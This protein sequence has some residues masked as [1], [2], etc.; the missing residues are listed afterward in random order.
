MN[1]N[2]TEVIKVTRHELSEFLETEERKK[3]VS[4]DDVASAKDIAKV[5]REEVQANKQ[6]VK[7]TRDF[8]LLQLQE[9]KEA[10]IN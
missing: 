10:R 3:K 5:A 6:L 7:T 8:K 4:L 1:T 2:L 9:L